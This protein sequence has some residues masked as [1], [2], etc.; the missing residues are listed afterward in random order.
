MNR[1]LTACNST[2]SSEKT[3]NEKKVQGQRHIAVICD[4]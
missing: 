4:V 1:A 3:L 2:E